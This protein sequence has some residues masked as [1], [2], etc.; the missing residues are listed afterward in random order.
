MTA[1]RNEQWRRQEA[2]RMNARAAQLLPPGTT[3][4]E[5]R[6]W[7][8]LHRHIAGEPLLRMHEAECG[9]L[10]GYRKHLRNGEEPCQ[11]CRDAQN[12]ENTDRKRSERAV[13]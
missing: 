5:H 13:A 12:R 10:S 1:R 7:G 3:Y 4:V 2:D 8:N 6:D 11:S 9:E